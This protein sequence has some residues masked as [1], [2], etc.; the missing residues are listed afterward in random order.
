M[1][2]V[3]TLIVGR[4]TDKKEAG[5][6]DYV[7]LMG[8]QDRV[9]FLGESD[10]VQRIY[11]ALDIVV[12]SSAW[13]EGFSNSIGEAMSHGVP[14]VTTDVGES[15]RL[16]GDSGLVVP[17]G[18]SIK[19]AGALSRILSGHPYRTAQLGKAARKRIKK[20]Y[21]MKNIARRYHDLY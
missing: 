15:R 21:S 9:H 13:G 7:E 4:G 18:D 14:C 11:K 17:P 20:D 2:D 12:S 1:S 10:E 16:V 6:T 8:I 19:L 3:H 5:L